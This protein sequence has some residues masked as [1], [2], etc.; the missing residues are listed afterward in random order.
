MLQ[1][2]TE[3]E[4]LLPTANA[5]T[6]AAS[7]PAV[8]SPQEQTTPQTSQGDIEANNP[9]TAT[10]I[11]FTV[12]F[13][14]KKW[15]VSCDAARVVGDVFFK[16]GG[17]VGFFYTA[18]H[19]GAVLLSEHDADPHGDALP[20]NERVLGQILCLVFLLAAALIL[21]ASIKVPAVP[22]RCAD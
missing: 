14:G 9:E 6:S 18:V 20:N 19:K 2:D 12:K 13:G 15:K 3:H 11:L 5:S 17:G 4:Q 22:M 10:A 21:L 8:E 16:G 7:A 1:S